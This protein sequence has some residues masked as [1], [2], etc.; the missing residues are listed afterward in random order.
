M[1]ECAQVRATDGAGT[2]SQNDSSGWA[3]GAIGLE[4]FQ[5]AQRLQKGCFHV[6]LSASKSPL[7]RASFDLLA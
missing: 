5:M 2:H 3:Q 4:N 6:V 1:L 7:K